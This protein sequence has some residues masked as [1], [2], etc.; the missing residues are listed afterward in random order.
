MEGVILLDC[1]VI[2]GIFVRN[3]REVA[4]IGEVF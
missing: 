3:W 2:A 4:K 1:T